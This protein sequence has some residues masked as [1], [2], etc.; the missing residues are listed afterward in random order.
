METKWEKYLQEV[1]KTDLPKEALLKFKDNLHSRFTNCSDEMKPWM[2]FIL[3]PFKT[4]DKNHVMSWLKKYQTSANDIS[5]AMCDE[6]AEL[7][8]GDCV[9]YALRLVNL[10]AKHEVIK[11]DDGLAL[12]KGTSFIK[13]KDSP[14]TNIIYGEHSTATISQEYTGTTEEHYALETDLLFIEP[15][16]DGGFVFIKKEANV[17]IYAKRDYNDILVSKSESDTIYY[18][19]DL[20]S[21]CFRMEESVAKGIT[22]IQSFLHEILKKDL[23]ERFKHLIGKEASTS[24]S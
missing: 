8:Y 3:P 18:S 21:Y 1:L 19:K 10:L 6:F 22:E 4:P 5:N 16:K 13:G 7:Q 17:L 20:K 11:E 2:P 14:R 15:A 24:S 23:Q 9:A 12:V